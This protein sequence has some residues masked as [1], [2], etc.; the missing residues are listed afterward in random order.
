MN[1]KFLNK[2]IGF[3][4]QLLPREIILPHLEKSDLSPIANLLVDGWISGM[5]DRLDICQNDVVIVIGGYLGDSTSTYRNKFNSHVIVY[6]PIEEFYNSITKRFENDGRVTVVDK[7]VHRKTGRIEISVDDDRTSMHKQSSSEPFFISALGVTEVIE[8]AKELILDTTGKIFVEMNIEGAEFD[9]IE[10]LLPN[11]S[12][13]LKLGGLLIQ[14]H[15]FVDR[16]VIR[17]AEIQ[18]ALTEHFEIQFCYPWVWEYWKA[19][20]K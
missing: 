4:I 17:H 6:E 20:I 16:H 10:E 1:S 15:P 12:N 7:A 9:V 14:F 5:M 18:Q 8:S 3:F 19:K 2:F 13:S 11:F